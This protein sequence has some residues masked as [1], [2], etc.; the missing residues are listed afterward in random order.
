[1]VGSYNYWLVLLSVVV[2]ITASYVALDLTSRVVASHGRKSGP[3]WLGGGAA[4][5]GCGIW[6]MHFIGMLAFSAP[7][8]MS[9][10]VPVMGLSL[11]IAV[12]ASGFALYVTSRRSLSPSRLL[13]G[14]SLLGFAIAAMHYTGM[15]AMRV[16]PPIHYDFGLIA[17]SVVIAVGTSITALWSAFKLRLETIFTAFGKKAGSATVLGL[18]ICLMHYTGMAAAR[19]TPDSISTATPHNISQV[20]LAII[21]GGFT[22]TFLI[23]TLLVSAVEAYFAEQS[24]Q[25][26]RSLSTLNSEL[27]IRTAELSRVNALLQQEVQVRKQTEDALRVAR[28]ELETRVIERTAELVQSNESLHEQMSERKAA[29][30]ALRVSE[31]Q[32][33]RLFE[34]R[35]NLVR[36][37]H[38]NIVQSIFI[39]GKITGAEALIRWNDPRTGLVP[40]SQFISVIEETGLIYEVGRWALRKAVEDYL[41]WRDAGLPAV[42][43]A[44]N[45]SQLQLR[46]R[47]FIDEIKEA[48]S[49]DARA[50]AGLELEIT[51]SV[52]M[53]NVTHSIA[54][55]QSIRAL[56]VS[57]AIDDFGTGFSSLSYLSKLPADTLKIDRS[58]VVDM[59]TAPEGLALVSTIINLAHSLKLKV[60]AE[61]VET[62]EQSRL[63]R[64]LS[65]D[66]MQGYLFSKPVPCEIFESRF[67]APSSAG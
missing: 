42:R 37:L 44:V 63:L 11:L 60:V 32:L 3:F 31:Q 56:G 61:G 20:T 8:R 35:E 53:E 19:L 21:L 28:D 6:S 59:T 34:E 64:L 33:R 49:I 50:A 66:E 43:I 39:S 22:L 24:A 38:D 62:E 23:S 45:V 12:A 9:Y 2:A 18:G 36:N 13:A 14:G 7:S 54:I 65:C 58:F 29:D 51:E 26:A 4:A 47:G 30:H 5:M 40:P 67:L 52:V 25:Q 15:A 48:I 10:A 16:L 1:L 57:I 27:Q 46:T 55:L 17:L 41:R